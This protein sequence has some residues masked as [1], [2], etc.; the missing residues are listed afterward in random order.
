MWSFILRIK[1][2]IN[3]Y[4]SLIMILNIYKSFAQISALDVTAWCA[5]FWAVKISWKQGYFMCTKHPAR[6]RSTL[7]ICIQHFPC[8]TFEGS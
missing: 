7:Y 8:L 3:D 4:E 6:L 1:V 5:L 2:A